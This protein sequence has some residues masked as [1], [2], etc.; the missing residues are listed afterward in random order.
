MPAPDTK[1]I[2]LGFRCYPGHYP[3]PRSRRAATRER[4]IGA[5][6]TA[7]ATPTESAAVFFD[8]LDAERGRCNACAISWA[9]GNQ[10]RTK[11]EVGTYGVTA[12]LHF[13]TKEEPIHGHVKLWDFANQGISSALERILGSR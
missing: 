11:L 1:G 8:E 7:E 3:K 2:A 5:D 12:R 13:P 4:E 6:Q 10:E 9:G